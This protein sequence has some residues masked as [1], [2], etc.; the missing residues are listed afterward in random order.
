MPTPRQL[1]KIINDFKP[2]SQLSF[3]E[4]LI[5]TEYLTKIVLHHRRWYYRL[6]DETPLLDADYD[7]IEIRIIKLAEHFPELYSLAHPIIS[8]VGY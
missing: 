5:E 4:A 2:V 3:W 8:E 6:S 1:L 7:K